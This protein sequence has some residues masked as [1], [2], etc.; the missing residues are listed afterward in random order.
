MAPSQFTLLRL[1]K[2]ERTRYSQIFTADAIRNLHPREFDRLIGYLYQQQGYKVS[3]DRF[4]HLILDKG[5]AK[6]IAFCTK[7][8]G[9]VPIESIHRLCRLAN[10]Q[11]ANK[12]IL[13]T[14]GHVDEADRNDICNTLRG[15]HSQT[16]EFHEGEKAV[17]WIADKNSPQRSESFIEAHS[18]EIAIGMGVLTALLIAWLAFTIIRDFQSFSTDTVVDAT[19]TGIGPDEAVPSL[20]T[21]AAANSVPVEP[22]ITPEPTTIPFP[23][24]PGAVGAVYFESPIE[25]NSDLGEWDRVPSVLSS[26]RVYTGTLATA[27]LG[28]LSAIWRIGW[29]DDYIYVAV[30]VYDDVHVQTQIGRGIYLG[31]SVEFQIDTDM[32]DDPSYVDS[33]DYIIVLSPGDFGPIEPSSY[34]FQGSASGEFNLEVSLDIPLQVEQTPSGYIVEAAIPW[35]VIDVTPA[36][37]MV[38][39]LALNVTDNDVPGT[40]VQEALYSH[41]ADRHYL[42][43]A[44]WGTLTLLN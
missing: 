24:E 38:V 27:H 18:R 26:Y 43:P 35:E 33:D 34:C 28:T 14:M 10:S 12:A 29:N 5:R 17:S 37:G 8:E 15:A 3:L 21:P 44:T 2:Q 36:P 40:A 30:E 22:I 23:T 42:Q 25:I 32:S 39:G 1:S 11:R 7:D 31:D 19:N 9:A 4:G 13:F 6:S 20:L 16:I 41:V